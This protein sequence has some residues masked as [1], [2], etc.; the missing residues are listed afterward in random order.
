MSFTLLLFL[1]AVNLS[2]ALALDRHFHSE[3]RSV[4][5]FWASTSSVFSV[6]AENGTLKAK[7]VAMKNPRLDIKN[8]KQELRDE[9][10][11]GMQVLSHYAFANGKWRGRIY[12]P[13]T[14]KTYRSSMRIDEEGN[15][16]L[17]AQI[18]FF[19][20][21]KTFLPVSACTD[22]IVDMLEGSNLETICLRNK[23]A[24]FNS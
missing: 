23:A 15:L 16:R 6:Y 19:S 10:I 12:N 8:P 4:L 20:K 1:G 14:G 11:V 13:K 17:K 9:P 21:T 2:S 22:G 18:A 24:E 7:V 3:H 5:G